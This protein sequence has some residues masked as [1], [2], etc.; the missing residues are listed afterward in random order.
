[1]ATGDKLFYSY[2][3]PWL[4]G[5]SLKYSEN[6]TY[7]MILNEKNHKIVHDGTEYG[8]FHDHNYISS[9][10]S[11][12]FINTSNVIT[13]N[14]GGCVCIKV[15][16]Q[17]NNWG[18]KDISFDVILSSNKNECAKYTIGGR[19]GGSSG[20]PT[21]HS[22]SGVYAHCVASKFIKI[23]R[24]DGTYQDATNEL[25]D[26]QV[27]FCYQWNRNTG[28]TAAALQAQCYYPIVVIGG[29]SPKT[30][31][32]S[33]CNITSS[34]NF[35]NSSY[36]F[37][38]TNA[39]NDQKWQIFTKL[40]SEITTA[41]KYYTSNTIVN[42][43]ID[44]D[45]ADVSNHLEIAR[46]IW[47]QPF[48]G[49]EDI[50]GNFTLN[51]T[52]Y[53]QKFQTGS[54]NS[55]YLLRTSYLRVNSTNA[56]RTSLTNSNF[57]FDV[58]GDSRFSG[59]VGIGWQPQTLVNWPNASPR[60]YI[61]G[62]TE[63]PRIHP[64]S[65][66]STPYALFT[67]YGLHYL[68][69]PVGI[70]VHP[71]LDG[72][73]A[74]GTDGR[75]AVLTV[76][77][78]YETD[79]RNP[80]A[81]YTAAGDNIFKNGDTSIGI[82]TYL[83]SQKRRLFVNGPGTNHYAIYSQEGMN[84]F[85]NRV[86]IGVEPSDTTYML[87]VNGK[88]WAQNGINVY[89]HGLSWNGTQNCGININ[90]V[91]T[92]SADQL[93]KVFCINSLKNGDVYTYWNCGIY[94]MKNSDRKWAYDTDANTAYNLLLYTANTTA[95]GHQCLYA[96]NANSDYKGTVALNEGTQYN[97]VCLG[98]ITIYRTTLTATWSINTDYG[99]ITCGTLETPTKQP[100]TTESGPA[101]ANVIGN[102]AIRFIVSVKSTKYTSKGTLNICSA[103]PVINT[104]FAGS[105][106][107]LVTVSGYVQESSNP[108][109]QVYANVGQSLTSANQTGQG[110]Y[111][112]VWADRIYYS[113]SAVKSKSDGLASTGG[114]G[115]IASIKVTLFG[116]WT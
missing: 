13:L 86:G 104:V 44:A 3:S 64:T 116:Y 111:V 60:L 87:N 55:S 89:G 115:S 30:I 98:I 58:N 2:N 23:K 90:N 51:S 91:N 32:V 76:S 9:L 67:E 93:I 19:L 47:G 34:E 31:N 101:T 12:C 21:Q 92:S 36:N 17:A 80:I 109:L 29:T 25:S 81:I 37:I 5:N 96:F 49:S 18:N 70:C 24:N 105:P 4:Q 75:G 94:T 103:I 97:L 85:A 62:M 79:N 53:W 20:H 43:L 73:S 10:S 66:N 35:E 99:N 65:N 33:I 15:P 1:M 74:G 59:Y 77:S 107:G 46:N 110:Q 108:I 78:T 57:A 106:S 83:G 88:I 54:D 16:A 112:A 26:L 63:Q 40:E 69:D 22:W 42:T 95:N 11:D 48:N 113:S 28:T 100:G 41:N 52:N 39:H 45:K 8:I 14:P 71:I 7:S 6:Y 114:A 38:D 68:G 102:G 56:T 82:N 61:T 27:R 72:N 50:A 84:Y